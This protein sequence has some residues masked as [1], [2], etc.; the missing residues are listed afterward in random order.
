MRRSNVRDTLAVAA[1]AVATHA[2]DPRT[3]YTCTHGLDI[4]GYVGCWASAFLLVLIPHWSFDRKRHA[5][6]RVRHYRH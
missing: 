3:P 6:I 1:V 2:Q 5:I 4:A